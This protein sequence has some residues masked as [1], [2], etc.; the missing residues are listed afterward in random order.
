M[1]QVVKLKEENRGH[2]RALELFVIKEFLE[3]SL[4]RKWEELSQD[5]VDQ[6]GAS[7]KSS[8]EHYRDSGLSYVAKDKGQVVGFIFAKT[9]DHVSN[10]PK[11]VWVENMGVHPS[12]RRHG[13]AYQLLKK[14]AIEG[15]K[16]GAKA[17]ESMI[18]H[19]NSKSIMLHKKVG[20]FLDARRVMFLDLEKFK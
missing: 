20:F 5:F 15:K 14:V 17:V 9:I 18:M 19:D 10:I 7:S 8:W 11:V 3:G 1:V 6:L 4:N 2:V 16:Q 12:H 13:I